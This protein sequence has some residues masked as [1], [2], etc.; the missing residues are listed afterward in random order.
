MRVRIFQPSKSTMQSGRAGQGIWR[1]DP[2]LPTARF[3]DPLMG[4]VAADDTMNELIGR[5]RFATQE[6]AVAFAEAHGMDYT[7]IPSHRRTVVPR[8]YLDN[9]KWHKS[10][11]TEPEISAAKKY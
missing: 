6:H 3:N 1:M 5:L 2:E 4:W 11:A 9:F 7:I 10:Q 8:N